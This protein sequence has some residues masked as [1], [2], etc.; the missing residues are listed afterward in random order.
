MTAKKKKKNQSKIPHSLTPNPSPNEEG[1][2]E[3]YQ[4]QNK[5]LV[6]LPTRELVNLLQQLIDLSTRE[7]VNLLQQL[8]YLSTR[9]LVDLT[10]NSSTRLLMNLSTRLLVN[11]F[12]H[13]LTHKPL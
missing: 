10:N 7:L 2:E 8:V 5:L 1:S 3:Y 13:Q 4:Q 6:H 12:T 9:E 11:S